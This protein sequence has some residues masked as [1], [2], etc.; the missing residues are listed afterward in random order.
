MLYYVE[1]KGIKDNKIKAHCHTYYH[2]D[3]DLCAEN[4]YIRW[5]NFKE[6]TLIKE[7][8]EY[9]KTHYF[10][11]DYDYLAINQLTTAENHDSSEEVQSLIEKSKEITCYD[12]FKYALDPR[13]SYLNSL[14]PGDGDVYKKYFLEMASEKIIKPIERIRKFA[15]GHNL[16]DTQEYLDFLDTLNKLSIDQDRSDK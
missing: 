13:D 8:L 15:E 14:R 4:I 2:T 1:V 5:D 12:P 6:E 11:G 7:I 3:I 16:L 10:V 9:F